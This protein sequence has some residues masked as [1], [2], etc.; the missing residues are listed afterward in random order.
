MYQA[1][2]L[3]SQLQNAEKREIENHMI[4]PTFLSS[5]VEDTSVVRYGTTNHSL[6]HRSKKVTDETCPRTSVIFTQNIQGLPWKDRKLESLLDP[7]IEI[8]I[9][10]GFMI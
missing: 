1:R 9:S 10:N 2:E 6:R 7:L 8:M 3:S 5:S 4:K